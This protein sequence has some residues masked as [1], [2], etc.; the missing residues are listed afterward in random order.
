MQQLEAA[1]LDGLQ[2]Q[3]LNWFYA[4]MARQGVDCEELMEVETVQRLAR[5]GK[6]RTCLDVRIQ[7]ANAKREAKGF[8]E[9]FKEGF[10]EG[11]EEAFEEGRLEGLEEC[12]QE[13]RREGRLEGLEESRQES[14][15][16]QREL[17]QAQAKRR[18]GAATADRL[19]ACLAEVREH[20]RLMAIGGWLFDCASGTE[21]LDRVEG[22]V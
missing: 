13:R 1:E 9:G 18:F 10:E 3:F 8:K 6:I 7:A 2:Q 14:L 11:F 22:R 17:L 20:D 16:Q 21:L 5:E 19:A 12:R 4:V 15:E